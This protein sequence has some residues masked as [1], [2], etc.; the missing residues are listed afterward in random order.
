MISFKRMMIRSLPILALII[1]FFPW[2][3]FAT[4]STHTVPIERPD[5]TAES[6]FYFM[7]FA[8]ALSLAINSVSIYTESIEI[9]I[10]SVFKKIDSVL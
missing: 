9:L 3:L 8:G 2:I 4:F 10:E 5:D 6:K 1:A 7:L